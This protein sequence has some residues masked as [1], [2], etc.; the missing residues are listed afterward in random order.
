MNKMHPRVPIYRLDP[1][2][3]AVGITVCSKRVVGSPIQPFFKYDPAN[4][5]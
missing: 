2:Y 5:G 1:V 4:G 3:G